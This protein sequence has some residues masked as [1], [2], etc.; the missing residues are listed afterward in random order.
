MKL[1]F[2][3]DEKKTLAELQEEEEYAEEPEKCSKCFCSVFNPN[4]RLMTVKEIRLV[5]VCECEHS[6]NWHYEW[7]GKKNCHWAKIAGQ[8]ISQSRT[9]PCGCKQYTPKQMVE[10]AVRGEQYG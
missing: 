4:P 3:P 7:H 9:I 5:E 8:R 2:M 1:P 10:I 6:E